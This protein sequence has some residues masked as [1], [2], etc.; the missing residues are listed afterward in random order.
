MHIKYELNGIESWI[1]IYQNTEAFTPLV[2]EIFARHEL[3]FSKLQNLTPGSNAVFLVD[4]KVIK[5]FAPPETG[6][7]NRKAFETEKAAFKHINQVAPSPK[8]LH[9]GTIKDQY[10]FSYIIMEQVAGRNFMDITDQEKSNLITN[11]QTF[12]EAMNITIEDDNI[13]IWTLQDCLANTRWEDFPQKFQEERKEIL[14]TLSFENPVY[15]H[16]DLKA[17]N[18][19]IDENNQLHMIDFAD[20]HQA[21]VIYEWPYIVFGILSC[22]L[23]MLELYFGKIDVETFIVQLT[24]GIMMHKFGSFLL[25]Q[26]CEI[27]NIE[28]EEITEMERVYQLIRQCLENGDTEII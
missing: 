16:G 13:P 15:V 26:I 11:I 28:L 1:D 5:L 2:K 8:L 14:K 20:S 6:F 10:D 23:E 4:D 19:I 18:L 17:A 22:N 21:P 24:Q 3:E 7:A 27:K 12:T 9:A 25:M